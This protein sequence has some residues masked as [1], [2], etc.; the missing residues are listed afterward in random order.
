MLIREFESCDGEK[1]PERMWM[2]NEPDNKEGAQMS[3]VMRLFKENG[4]QSGYEDVSSFISAYTFCQVKFIYKEL[5]SLWMF[6]INDILSIFPINL[7]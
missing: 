4:T 2:S 3:V 1:M 6:L 5:S 7:L